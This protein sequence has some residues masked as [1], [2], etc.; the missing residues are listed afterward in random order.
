MEKTEI[1][2]CIIWKYMVKLAML[3]Q[4]HETDI[5]RIQDVKEEE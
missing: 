4:Q 1:R 2:Y 5:N 3:I